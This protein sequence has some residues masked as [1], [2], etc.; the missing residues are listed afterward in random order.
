MSV[1][2]DLDDGAMT[3]VALGLV[4]IGAIV[5]MA[6]KKISIPVAA[7]PYSVW[8]SLAT[9]VDSLFAA[10]PLAGGKTQNAIDHFLG[11]VSSW[12]L[13]NTPNPAKSS[14]CASYAS[15]YDNG[16]D[17]STVATGS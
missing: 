5:Y 11:G 8:G 7:Y 13:D 3:I 15:Q 4:L 16:V 14:N 10:T 17:P 12:L 2:G 1:E 9:G 6:W